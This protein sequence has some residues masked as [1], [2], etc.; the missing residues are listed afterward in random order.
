M[1]LSRGLH[2]PTQKTVTRVSY[3]LSR[4]IN[5]QEEEGMLLYID[6]NF[7]KH[8]CLEEDFL[9]PRLTQGLE[10]VGVGVGV[11]KTD[12]TEERLCQ[13]PM[14]P[15]LASCHGCTLVC[16]VH[17]LKTTHSTFSDSLN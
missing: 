9:I 10:Q 7:C 8:S 13:F 5:N 14:G 12:P 6:K 15:G 11:G 17:S 16:N 1:E 2:P 4:A 3:V